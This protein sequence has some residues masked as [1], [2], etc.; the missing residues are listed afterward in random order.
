M[1]YP[2][3]ISYITE[4]PWAILESKAVAI[5]ELMALREAGLTL[6]QQEIEARIGQPKKREPK[7]GSIAVLPV[8]GVLSHRMNLLNEVSGGTSTERLTKDFRQFVGDDTVGAIV[9]DIDSEGGVIDGIPELAAEIYR[10]RGTKP[11]VAV[12]NSMAASAAY[13]IASAADEIVVTPSGSVG[14]IGVMHIHAEQSQ[15]AEK[16]GVKFTVTK[17]GKYKG[18][19]NPFE[20]LSEEAEEYIQK[21]VDKCY[22]MFVKDVARSRGVGAAEVRNGFG[23]GRMVLAKD[24]KQLGMV[25]RIETLDETLA[26]LSTESG[27]SRAMRA[28][29]VAG[30]SA[31]LAEDVPIQVYEGDPVSIAAPDEPVTPE[32]SQATTKSVQEPES[33]V[34][35]PTPEP[36][37]EESKGPSA[38]YLRLK[39]KW[40]DR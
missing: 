33:Q 8:M 39:W 15:R 32:G 4:Q 19:G 23:E 1:N 9:L 10:S 26:R 24:A 30:V 27:R 12:A 16:E 38:D 7:G 29:A 17:A 35:E 37:P 13:Y 40:R 31:T 14:S 36:A 11:I 25:D 6:T 28:E 20:P 34:A 18:E 3:I 22:E 21:T 5:M 2:R